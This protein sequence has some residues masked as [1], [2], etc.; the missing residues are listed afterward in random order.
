MVM[1][2]YL[3]FLEGWGKYK[4]W[5]MHLKRCAYVITVAAKQKDGGHAFSAGFQPDISKY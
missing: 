3:L 1:V 5:I 2:A 4:F